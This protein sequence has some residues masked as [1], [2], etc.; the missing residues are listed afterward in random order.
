MS[1]ES[2]ANQYNWVTQQLSSKNSIYK[3]V[4][5]VTNII[6]LDSWLNVRY[7]SIMYLT[8]VGLM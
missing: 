2:C 1:L 6:S 7:I 5:S 4:K 3:A 8:L